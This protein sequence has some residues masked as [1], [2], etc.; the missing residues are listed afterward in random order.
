MESIPTLNAPTIAQHNA[1]PDIAEPTRTNP[2]ASSH[3]S[4]Q[5]TKF[6]I[7]YCNAGGMSTKLVEFYAAITCNDY[8]AI[9]I[10]E[11]WFKPTHHDAEICPPGW[12]IFRKDREGRQGGGVM[13]ICKD[14]FKPSLVDVDC[15]GTEQIWVK[16]RFSDSHLFIGAAYVP[17]RSTADVVNNAISVYAHIETLLSDSDEALLLS[18]FN[19]PGIEWMVDD[20][21]PNVFRPTHA[22]SETEVMIAEILLGHNLYQLNGT[23]NSFGNLL[24]TIF[25]TC[26]DDI[27]L[28]SPCLPL[29]HGFG[30]NQFHHPV[31]IELMK[32]SPALPP[33]LSSTYDY[34][35]ADYPAI[36]LV[37]GEVDWHAH[38]RDL[39]VDEMLDRFYEIVYDIRER[40][41]PK[42]TIKGPKSRPWQSSHQ[43]NL[44]TKRRNLSRRISRS[45]HPQDVAALEQVRSQIAAANETDYR[46]Y[47]VNIGTK[48]KSD[49]KKFWSVV[50]EKRRRN[51][52]PKVVHLENDSADEPSGV[53]NLFGRFF[54]SV[55]SPLC[56]DELPEEEEP[57]DSV[58]ISTDVSEEDVKKLIQDLDSGKGAGPDDLPPRFFKS[59][60]SSIATPLTLIFMTSLMTQV[61]P[62]KW[63]VATVTPIFKSGD[64]SNVRNYRPISI[65]SC[66]AKM[67]DKLM[68]Q[69]IGIALDRMI[70]SCQHAYREG[71]STT[72]N[73]LEFTS[74][75]RNEM[76][77]GHQVDAIYL[78]FSKAFDTLCHRSLLKKLKAYG[79][80]AGIISWIRSYLSGRTQH[81]KMDGCLSSPV[82]VSS[83]VP[84]GSHLGPILF[85]LYLNDLF[86]M[87]KNVKSLAYADDIK[88]FKT[89]KTD[90][91]A[92]TLQ[93]ALNTI[94][95]WCGINGMNLN[96]SKCHLISFTR[97]HT[98]HDHTYSIGNS[99]FNRVNQLM[100]LGVLLNQKMDFNPHTAF[101]CSKAASVLGLVKRF[102]RNFNDISVAKVLYCALVR[103]RLEYAGAVWAPYHKTYQDKLESIQ[104]KFI[105][106]ALPCRRDPDTYRLPPYI[107]R[108]STIGLEPL[109]CRRL[110]SQSTII[111]D[112][113]MGRMRSEGLRNQIAPNSNR[114]T[115]S[116][117]WLDVPFHRTDYGRHEPLNGCRLAFNRVSEIF[118]SGLS[119]VAFRRTCSS[120]F[121]GEDDATGAGGHV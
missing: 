79:I 63:K 115:R 85:A 36:N 91:D 119:R 50:D 78:D 121:I 51:V 66:A 39:N 74:H 37:L 69:R 19:Q 116:S 43:S 70:S 29:C 77:Q 98:R 60:I 120:F 106:F 61:F 117:E 13:I 92:N 9:V 80:S 46:R 33:Q 71:Y 34:R 35:R 55:F 76:E 42:R 25:S 84:Q 58:Q 32:H 107:H 65:L 59:T 7:F 44:R 94:I 52:S 26:Y 6:R 118:L 108:L 27:E 8:E 45:N 30:S 114:R 67:L 21:I 102:A 93:A 109:W 17:P 53:A 112:L 23:V 28:L 73:L 110:V 90:S 86:G 82:D 97:R 40:Y 88:I 2:S 72:T 48:L 22:N 56:H 103:S 96:T 95:Q 1:H 16:A 87:L 104:K 68:S 100:D 89:I 24:E 18:D 64:R 12:S 31:A 83:G 11:T 14:E 62:S 15:K 3:A 99:F 54:G 81:V 105:M 49:P 111:H 4:N 20:E 57:I 5:R 75:V 113:L 101:T 38:L 47:M 10:T 41:I